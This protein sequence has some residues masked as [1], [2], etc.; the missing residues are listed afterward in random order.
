MTVVWVIAIF[1]YQFM[2]IPVYPGGKCAGLPGTG[3]YRIN[4]SFW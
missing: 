1:S 3:L 2:T 4:V